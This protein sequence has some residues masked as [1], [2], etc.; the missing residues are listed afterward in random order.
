MQIA[1]DADQ[2]PV[3]DIAVELLPGQASSPPLE[4][5]VAASVQRELERLNSE[6][7][8]YA[9]AERRVPHI[10]LLAHADP[11]YFP[12]GVKHRYTRS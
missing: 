7:K 10:R 5:D 11:S 9:P 8:N 12:V 2:N 1:H 3:L 4:R 6:F